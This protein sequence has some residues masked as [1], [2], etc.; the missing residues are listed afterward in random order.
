VWKVFAPRDPEG[1][2][3]RNA[4]VS[5]QLYAAAPKAEFDPLPRLI[6]GRSF[7]S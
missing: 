6:G 3:S 7:D 1:G 5:T 2:T 4:D